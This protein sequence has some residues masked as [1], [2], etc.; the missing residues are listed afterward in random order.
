[1]AAAIPLFLQ[2]AEA[3][4][5][6]SAP[7]VA[8]T[9]ER[10]LRDRGI[11]P[12]RPALHR[13]KEA[14]GRFIV[15]PLG[16]A[17]ARGVS[18]ALKYLSPSVAGFDGEPYRRALSV[19]V[20]NRP[21]FDP[22]TATQQA[23]EP[24]PGPAGSSQPMKKM[25][26]K[27]AKAQAMAT[28]AGKSSV[29]RSAAFQSAKQQAR[30]QM[31]RVADQA[32]S[33][34][35]RGVAPNMSRN[36]SKRLE[37]VDKDGNPIVIGSD[38]VAAAIASDPASGGNNKQGGLLLQY[39]LNPQ[40]VI[41][42]S[43]NQ[44]S[45]LYQKFEFLQVG[46][47][48]ASSEAFTYGGSI[49]CLWDSDIGDV[50]GAGLQLVQQAATTAS[51]H[52]C[53]IL[54]STIWWYNT[55]KEATGEY[56]VQED[57]TTT[58]GSR[59]SIQ[60]HC[61]VFFVNPI[62]FPSTPSYPL[63]F[64]SFILHYKVRFYH[65]QIDITQTVGGSALGVYRSNT[66]SATAIFGGSW[67]ANAAFNAYCNVSAITNPNTPIAVGS[68]CFLPVNFNTP[69]IYYVA[70]NWNWQNGGSTGYVWATGAS[71][72]TLSSGIGVGGTSSFVIDTASQ[73]LA[74]GG[75]ALISGATD[76]IR[77][78]TMSCNAIVRVTAVPSTINVTLTATGQNFALNA[79]PAL[80][81]QFQLFVVPIDITGGV[82]RIRQIQ[83]QR[84]LVSALKNSSTDEGPEHQPQRVTKSLLHDTV[85][86]Q[87]AGLPI[88]PVSATLPEEAKKTCE[89]EKLQP[90]SCPY[91]A[92]KHLQMYG[93]IPGSAV[94]KRQEPEEPYEL[95][96]SAASVPRSMSLDRPL[97][98]MARQ[99]ARSGTT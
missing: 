2:G 46:I 79:L 56:Y 24:N 99:P 20:F 28:G 61:K 9:A 25:K 27:L 6:A 44:Y 77:F 37:S 68:L 34:R 43:L 53:P 33:R 51:A 95:V 75:R 70:A 19:P 30:Q 47:E 49:N 26:A 67:V 22:F 23:V 81:D 16:R 48:F 65:R 71:T 85:A 98:V 38:Y 4:L 45:E 58:A 89:H 55:K 15:E 31:Q 78:F 32:T 39:N 36:I 94:V 12:R 87:L 17:T 84:M 97:L 18:K 63:T 14:T 64:G 13:A 3:A 57:L 40:Q 88:A 73:N 59:Q 69:G 42:A 96:T 60:G 74:G 54:R 72:P 82:T 83:R 91:C 52:E 80:G 50:D 62:S 93:P 21:D 66:Y 8:N 92:L 29:L 5:A 10:M 11:D 35:A 41:T 90:M 1:M 7:F 76:S 86:S